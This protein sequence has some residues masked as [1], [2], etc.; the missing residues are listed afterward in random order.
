MIEHQDFH[1]VHIKDYPLPHFNLSYRTSIFLS[2]KCLRFGIVVTLLL[3]TTI[4]CQ[5]QRKPIDSTASDTGLSTEI[6][7][8]INPAP[9]T[10][11]LETQQL[12]NYHLGQNQLKHFLETEGRRNQKFKFEDKDQIR[13]QFKIFATNSDNLAINAVIRIVENIEKSPGTSI[14]ETALNKIMDDLRK[15]L[16][17]RPRNSGINPPA[18]RLRNDH[19]FSYELLDRAIRREY[20]SG[21]SKEEI[22]RN[23][24]TYIALFLHRDYMEFPGQLQRNSSRIYRELSARFDQYLAQ[25]QESDIRELPRQASLGTDNL[26]NELS[27]NYQDL[28]I[29]NNLLKSQYEELQ[30]QF[31]AVEQKITNPKFSILD[32]FWLLPFILVFY[33]GYLE[34]N[35]PGL[36]SKAIQNLMA[37][38]N[39]KNSSESDPDQQAPVNTHEVK[40]L[41]E[42]LNNLEAKLAAMTNETDKKLDEIEIK[43]KGL[44]ALSE[45]FDQ[46]YLID[47]EDLE[48][49]IQ[50]E[51]RR[52]LE[53]QPLAQGE[54]PD[55]PILAEKIKGLL[56]SDPTMAGLMIDAIMENGHLDLL[57]NKIK[58]IVEKDLK[59]ELLEEAAP[60]TEGNSISS[61]E[62]MGLK[63][64][65]KN[66][67]EK[68]RLSIDASLEQFDKKI[69][70]I[71]VGIRKELSDLFAKEDEQT[72]NYS[73][74]LQTSVFQ[75]LKSHIDQ[76]VAPTLTNLMDAKLQDNSDQ[77]KGIF[78]K[79][80]LLEQKFQKLASS[81]VGSHISITPVAS[82][83]TQAQAQPKRQQSSSSFSSNDSNF[84]RAL[85][86][87][88]FYAPKPKIGE[89][90]VLFYHSKLKSQADD[91][92]IFIIRIVNDTQAVYAINDS[93][94]AVSNALKYPDSYLFP[95]VDIRDGNIEKARKISMVSQGELKKDGLNWAISKKAIIDCQ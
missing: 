72:A 19:E 3:T 5:Q 8:E 58:T 45:T 57:V 32:L 86:E 13:S 20:Q 42:N 4:A 62:L 11:D 28:K 31:L 14:S 80:N 77:L 38:F 81:S 22:K 43:T 10:I 40:N 15:K 94:A 71:Q 93:Q 88:T 84:I 21:G 95:A 53:S 17:Y 90:D 47:K 63:N 39:I 44:R 61:E 1:H 50:Q 54:T 6:P 68:V 52:Q 41:R 26:F 36:I 23:V 25:N 16:W 37:F 66:V 75:Q 67:D 55:S 60:K 83:E 91:N 74:E 46:K 56:Q 73:S 64:E 87:T 30:K 49:L 27:Q 78:E 24:L 7:A 48:K 51:V 18:N 69:E 65:L 9:R 2:M 35:R 59:A 92:C 79:L 29:E 34:V 33:A 89:N 12:T 82:K 70:S 85:G 76:Q